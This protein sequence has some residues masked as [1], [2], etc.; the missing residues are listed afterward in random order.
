MR[1]CNMAP[2]MLA[3]QNFNACQIKKLYVNVMTNETKGF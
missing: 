3:F 2:F 1:C